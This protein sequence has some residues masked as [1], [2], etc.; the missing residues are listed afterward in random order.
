M[1]PK[2]QQVQD[3]LLWLA[4]IEEI[5]QLK[6]RYALACDNEYDPA[7]LADLFTED[8]VWDGDFMGRAET[9]E[10][11]RA[12]FTVASTIVAFAVHGVSNPL[13]EVAGDTAKG[14]WYLHQ[15]MVL[16]GDGSCFWFCAQYE[17][18]YV[19]TSNG[20]KFQH[21]RVKPRAFTPFEKGFGKVLMADLP[22]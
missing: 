8:A 1:S 5:K 12:F 20:W 18:D 13:I 11:I 3:R 17:D 4:D 2:E 19:R 10:G 6:A 9:R 16:K 14:R 15:P 7:A 21:V 22:G